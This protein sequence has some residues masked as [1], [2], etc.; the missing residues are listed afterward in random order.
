MDAFL[1]SSKDHSQLYFQ[2]FNY[3]A[4]L[5]SEGI[6]NVGA[7]PKYAY[8]NFDLLMSK[9]DESAEGI[10]SGEIQSRCV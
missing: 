10:Q 9:A 2:A 4:D 8:R 7:D 5:T 6:E 1:V 3:G